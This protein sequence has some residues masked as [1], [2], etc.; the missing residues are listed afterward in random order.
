ME[1]WSEGTLLERRA[2]V[3]ALCEPGLL[4]DQHHASQIIEIIDGITASILDETDRKSKDFKVLRKSLAYGWSV[5]A[6]GQPSSGKPRMEKWIGSLDADIRWI[7]KQNLKKKR[8]T[9]LDADWVQAQL[10]TLG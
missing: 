9:R 7:M 6:V 10:E 4:E 8:L 3:A 1:T 2:V 5:L